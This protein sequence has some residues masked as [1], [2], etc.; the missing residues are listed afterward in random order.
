MSK[1]IR[2]FFEV[3]IMAVRIAHASI[4]ELN[5]TSGAKGDS[6][7]K[8]V[9]IRDYYVHKYGWNLVLRPSADIAD[10]VARNAEIVAQN[11]NVGYSQPDRNSLHTEAQRVGYD[12]NK[13][14]TPCNCDCS[15]DVT[16]CVIAAGVKSLEY[17]SNAPTTRTMESAFL[18]TGKFTVL[19]DSK[20]LTSDKYLMRGDVIVS[21]G[22]HTVIVL[23]NGSGVKSVEEV[24]REVLDGK[25]GVGAERKK[26]LNEAGYSYELVQSVVNRL[27]KER[28]TPEHISNKGLEL[29][30]SFEGCRLKAYQLAGEKYYSI[31]YGHHGADV[32]PNMTISQE[33]ADE[34][35]RVD[36]QKFERY[37]KQYATEFP[38]TQGMFDALVSYTYNRGQGGLK[39]LVA[40]CHT[41]QTMA[42]GLVKYWGKATRYEEALKK[43]RRKEREMFLS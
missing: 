30:K 13:I 6:T 38:L 39:E 41:P 17:T 43:R 35:F 34:L 3:Y 7:G 9:C 27:V 4:S 24:A 2:L 1:P 22:H 16:V 25:Y 20:Y 12:L 28:Q 33:R 36:L 29:L 18:R 26:K 23:D 19:K 32:L 8:E 5:T 10:K 15:S 21:V 11:N 40:N 37:V 42:D 14:T 31:G